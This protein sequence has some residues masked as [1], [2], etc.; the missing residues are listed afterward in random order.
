MVGFKSAALVSLAVCL[1][2]VGAVAQD[3]DKPAEGLPTITYAL[4]EKLRAEPQQGRDAILLGLEGCFPADETPTFST[5]AVKN[6][7]VNLHIAYFELIT[8]QHQASHAVRFVELVE[9]EQAKLTD[10][11]RS[12]L[13][14]LEQAGLYEG[15]M[16]LCVAAT[17]RGLLTR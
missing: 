14:V 10:S 2:A 5:V 4:V 9:Q 6:A 15:R 12:E 16:L 17:A 1:G 8:Q 11:E 3:G 7:A 13:V